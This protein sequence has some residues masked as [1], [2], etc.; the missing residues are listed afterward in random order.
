MT[1]LYGRN[2]KAK[3]RVGKAVNEARCFCEEELSGGLSE[4]SS[5]LFFFLSRRQIKSGAAGGGSRPEVGRK[6]V[7]IKLS[8]RSEP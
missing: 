1:E 5:A 7:A 6:G 2:L 3:L 4:R 8:G